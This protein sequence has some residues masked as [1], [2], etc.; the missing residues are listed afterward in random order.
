MYTFRPATE[1]I[2]QLRELIRDRVIRYDSERLRIVTE[3]YRQNEY[4]PPI[5]KRPL[6][7]K[8]LCEQMTV[9]VED[10]EIIV[11]NKGPHFFS[12][13]QYPEWGIS[14]W[15]MEPIEKGEWTLKED[16]LYHNPENEELRNTISAE[17]Y[18]VLDRK[19]V[20]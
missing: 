17:D 14:D 2:R 8:A 18:R 13:P 1:R 4:L 20:V 5:L 15:L 3:A 10:S 6:A 9:L 12:S 16:G 19:S 11:G 7:F